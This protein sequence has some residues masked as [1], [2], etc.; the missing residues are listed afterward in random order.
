MVLK[1]QTINIIKGVDPII[2]ELLDLTPTKV[3]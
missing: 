3:L 1:W 2:I